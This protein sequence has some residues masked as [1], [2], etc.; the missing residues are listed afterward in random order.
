MRRSAVSR[1]GP[2]GLMTGTEIEFRGDGEASRRRRDDDPTDGSSSRAGRAGRRMRGPPEATGRSRRDRV[3]IGTS[4]GRHL[5]EASRRAATAYRSG[6]LVACDVVW[7]AAEAPSGRPLWSA[8][9]R[10]TR[11]I[12]TCRRRFPGRRACSQA[13]RCPA[14]PGPRVLPC[15]LLRT[16]TDRPVPQPVSAR[17]QC[18]SRRPGRGQSMTT[19]RPVP[20]HVT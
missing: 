11:P 2:V 12:G 16:A 19:R 14:L 7:L 3:D 6:A 13:G 20:E 17:T 8:Q 1:R 5:G 10:R 4:R 9:R 15:L 18:A